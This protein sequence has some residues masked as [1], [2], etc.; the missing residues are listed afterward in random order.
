MEK[1]RKSSHSIYQCKYH[2]VGV[3]KYRFK[4]LTGEIKDELKDKLQQICENMDIEII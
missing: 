4:V 1:Y 3:P 2:F